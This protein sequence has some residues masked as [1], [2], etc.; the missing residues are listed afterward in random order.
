MKTFVYTF[1]VGGRLPFPIDMLRYD[2]CTPNTEQDSHVIE[3]SFDP[4]S[5][6][7]EVEVQS[8]SRAASWTPTAAR[9]KS[10]GWEVMGYVRREQQ[11]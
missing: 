2:R 11:K 3:R 1:R 8:D 7:L 9:W 6:M 10:F 4:E 5:G